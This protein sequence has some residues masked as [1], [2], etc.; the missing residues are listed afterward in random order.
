MINAY[1]EK[2][3]N[4]DFTKE[5]R[6][7]LLELLYDLEK[8]SREGGNRPFLDKIYNQIGEYYKKK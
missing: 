2:A 7:A 1:I 3:K 5:D 4:F 6:F 8:K